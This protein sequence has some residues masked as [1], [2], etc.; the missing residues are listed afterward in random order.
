METKEVKRMMKKM[1]KTLI[2]TVRNS[3]SFN[4]NSIKCICKCNMN[5]SK[6]M[7]Y[8]PEVM[9]RTVKTDTLKVRRLIAVKK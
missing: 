3:S 5:N 7:T 1:R 4:S 2:N 9:T 8:P 6:R